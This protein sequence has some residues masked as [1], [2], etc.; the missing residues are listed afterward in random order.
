MT[1]RRS[2]GLYG[3]FDGEMCDGSVTTSYSYCKGWIDTD[4]RQD[5][6]RERDDLT[7]DY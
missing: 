5:S 6:S 1:E 2:G 4:K 3:V 7:W